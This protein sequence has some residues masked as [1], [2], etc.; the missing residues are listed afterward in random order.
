[1]HIRYWRIQLYKNVLRFDVSMEQTI[2]VQIIQTV[3]HLVQICLH[4]RFWNATLLALHEVVHAHVHQLEDKHD[5]LRLLLE[6]VLQHVEN[7]WMFAQ[8]LHGD[9]FGA[10]V[11]ITVTLETFL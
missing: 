6:E 9:D 8:L 3:E 10:I 11:N 5:L 4:P 7:V 1:M 2:P